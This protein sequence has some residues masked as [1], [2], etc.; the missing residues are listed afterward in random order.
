MAPPAP[1]GPEAYAQPVTPAAERTAARTE[2]RHDQPFG[3]GAYHAARSTEWFGAPP[4]AE[5]GGETGMK[6]SR[7]AS[8]KACCTKGW[9]SEGNRRDS[10]L[11][12]GLPAA[13][14]PSQERS[15]GTRA[16]RCPR[17]GSFRGSVPSDQGRRT[18]SRPVP[19]MAQGYSASAR[20]RKRPV[21]ARQRH[22]DS[23]S[24]SSRDRER[25]LEPVSALSPPHLRGGR[26]WRRRSPASAASRR[27]SHP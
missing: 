5:K 2:G 20:S 14:S 27:H 11:W 17:S 12:R 24:A 16:P 6:K 19:R 15:R 4:E 21:H 9:Q 25:R 23:R 10:P 26:H 1:E 3:T 22:P 7:H 13:R 8:P 18:S